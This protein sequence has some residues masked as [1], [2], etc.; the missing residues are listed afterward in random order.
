MGNRR[1]VSFILSGEHKSKNEENRRTKFNVILGSREHRKFRFGFGGTRENAEI[2]RE[3][4]NRSPPP[5]G[6]P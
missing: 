5:P 6:N 4:R 1:I 2:F 3:Q